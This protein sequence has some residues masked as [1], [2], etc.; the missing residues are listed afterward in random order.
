MRRVGLATHVCSFFTSRASFWNE[1]DAQWPPSTPPSGTL[2]TFMSDQ[3]TTSL[4][5]NH[6]RR[7]TMEQTTSRMRFLNSFTLELGSA[8]RARPP[9][10][11]P[12]AQ[13]LATTLVSM[14]SGNTFISLVPSP[15]TAARLAV[16]LNTS[17]YRRQR[18]S[19]QQ[20]AFITHYTC[21][22]GTGAFEEHADRWQS[23]SCTSA[24]GEGLGGRKSQEMAGLTLVLMDG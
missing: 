7:L 20:T 17:R 9:T 8:T 21:C 10:S 3:L 11:S 12:R 5:L 22:A 13:N 23:E 24:Q 2:R 18:Y 1:F 19:R 14:V 16:P 6:S 15:S 4:A